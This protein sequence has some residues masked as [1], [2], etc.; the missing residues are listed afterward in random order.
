MGPKS[1]SSRP[2]RAASRAG[3]MTRG[4]RT[5][6][7]AARATWTTSRAARWSSDL[8]AHAQRPGGGSAPAVTGGVVDVYFHV[9]NQ[10]AGLANGDVPDSQI[11]GQIA[12]L[13]AAFA[14][15]GWSFQLVA[16][17]RTNNATWYTGCPT[18]ETP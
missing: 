4:A 2:P 18:G 14:P 16:T 7:A 5:G 13:N 11:A 10:G 8:Q 1:W 9:I 15:S 17:D 6:P 3:R 12:G